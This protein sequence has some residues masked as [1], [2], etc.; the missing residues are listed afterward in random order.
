MK[1]HLGYTLAL[2]SIA[3][4]EVW[5]NIQTWG[6]MRDIIRRTFWPTTVMPVLWKCLQFSLWLYS[7]HAPTAEVAG[8]AYYNIM[9]IG[10]RPPLSAH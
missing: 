6:I 10:L 9:S 2:G 5:S 8:M 7:H 3:V 4:A 1:V